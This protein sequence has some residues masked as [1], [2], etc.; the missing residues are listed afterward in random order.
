MLCRVIAYKREKLT[1]GFPAM[2]FSM[3]MARIKCPRERDLWLPHTAKF[4]DKESTLDVIRYNVQGASRPG[5]KLT[6]LSALSIYKKGI[7]TKYLL[8]GGTLKRSHL[9]REIVEIF[10]FCILIFLVLRFVVQSYQV[11]KDE[12]VMVN[13][14]TYMFQG[15]ERGDVIVF[16]YPYADRTA[17]Y[18]LRV[19]G[20]PGDT[21][22]TDLTHLWINNVELKEPYITKSANL[23]G[24]TWTV[25]PNQYF[26]LCDNRLVSD[27]SRTWGFVPKD[28]IVGKAVVVYWPFNKFALIN[29]YANA[30]QSLP[31]KQ[32]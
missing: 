28:F 23:A 25:P 17:D 29:T 19:V 15:P 21:I 13:K 11:Q 16:H 5:Y 8:R 12:N 26:V 6:H 30:F 27:D 18:I 7:H 2:S 10:V 24:Q 3:F 14:I 22:K 32:K 9:K 4:G 1:F 20:L 31:T